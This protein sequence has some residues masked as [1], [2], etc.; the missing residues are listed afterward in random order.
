MT[1]STSALPRRA[2]ARSAKFALGLAVLLFGPAGSLR[3][4]PGWLYG[5]VFVGATIAISVYFLKHDPKLV[6]RRMHVGPAAEKEPSQKIIMTITSLGFVA[7]L[8][9]PGFD[10][11]WHWSAVP[12]WLVLLAN[13]GVACSFGIFFVVLKQNSYAASTIR[14]E[15]D[16]PVVS[17]GLYA[18][19]RHPLY[20]GALLFLICTPPALGSYWTYLVLVPVIPVLAWRL[21]DEERFLKRNLPGY[22]EY[23]GLTRFRLIPGIW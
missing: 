17:T 12:P 5:F 10:Y 1:A 9:L 15:P 20:A 7:L 4:W 18:I 2:W 6:E 3:F 16:Q 14:V 8:A 21:L 22:T 19:V 13:A 11:R 23:C